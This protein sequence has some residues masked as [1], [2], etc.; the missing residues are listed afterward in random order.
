MLVVGDKEAEN[1]TVAVRK[2]GESDSVVMTFE[3]FHAMIQKE[4]AEKA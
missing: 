1:N 2:H 3:E 4:I